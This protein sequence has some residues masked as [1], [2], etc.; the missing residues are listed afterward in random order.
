M[1]LTPR[2]LAE[3]DGKP[4][5]LAWIAAADAA[6]ARP[7]DRLTQAALATNFAFGRLAASEYASHLVWI[8]AAYGEIR[9]VLDRSHVLFADVSERD[10]IALFRPGPGADIPPA[11]A[12]GGDRVYFTPRFAPVDPVT[13]RGYGPKCRAAMV[14][15]ESVHVFDGRSGEPEIHVSEWD[16]RFDEMTLEQQLH[17]ASAYASFAAQTFHR[18]LD[19]SRDVRYGAGRPSE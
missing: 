3:I 10:A 4:M 7:T 8:R 18:V 15:H 12:I 14:I 6:L 16:P 5:A 2:E 9:R 11:Y 1:G 17:N 19:W 13:K